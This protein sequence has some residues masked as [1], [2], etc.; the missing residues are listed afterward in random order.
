MLC[1][2]ANKIIDSASTL[3]GT[4]FNSTPRRRREDLLFLGAALNLVLGPA[5]TKTSASAWREKS[6]ATMET[7]KDLQ[8]E[9]AALGRV[10][11]RLAFTADGNMSKVLGGLLPKLLVR[12]DE[13]AVVLDTI[14]ALPKDDDMEMVDGEGKAA[15]VE[16]TLETHVR[17]QIVEHVEAMFGHALERIKLNRTIVSHTWIRGLWEACVTTERHPV[18]LEKVLTLLQHA[19]AIC[20]GESFVGPLIRLLDQLHTSLIESPSENPTTL[21]NWKCAGWMVLDEIAKAAHLPVILD[22]DRDGLALGDMS[23]SRAESAPAASSE[24]IEAARSHGSGIFHL[25]LDV[26]LLNPNTDR[27]G[28]LSHDGYSRLQH[29]RRP[30]EDA[31]NERHAGVEAVR[32][33]LNDTR[34]ARQLIRRAVARRRLPGSWSEAEMM[35]FRHIKLAC[36]RF[37]VWPPQEGLLTGDEAMVL[38]TLI[39]NENSLHS[40]VASEY[41][42]SLVGGRKLVR[43]GQR[44]VSPKPPKRQLPVVTCLLVL[45]VGGRRTSEVPNLP[46]DWKDGLLMSGKHA[47]KA[48]FER[49][50]LSTD[51]A[52]HVLRDLGN[53]VE[54]KGR[55]GSSILRFFTDLVQIISE[56]HIEQSHSNA[57]IRSVDA[58][59][60]ALSPGM[61]WATRVWYLLLR[62]QAESNISDKEWVSFLRRRCWLVAVGVLSKA[63]HGNIFRLNSFRRRQQRR[64][65]SRLIDQNR[66]KLG[67]RSPVLKDCIQT[68]QEAYEMVSQLICGNVRSPEG[69]V[70][71]G[72]LILLLKCL[73]ADSVCELIPVLRETACR[74]VQV[75]TIEVASS[76]F[77]PQESRRLISS[78][79]FPL[80]DAAT[81]VCDLGRE[82][83]LVFA[84]SVLVKLDPLPARHLCSFLSGDPVPTISRKAQDALV[85]PEFV[86]EGTWGKPVKFDFLDLK[87][88]TDFES[89]TNDVSSRA[90]LL[91]V[92][93]GI[94]TAAGHC[95]LQ[96]SGF[97]VAEAISAAQADAALIISE[98]GVTS[99]V[100]KGA[101]MDESSGFCMHKNPVNVMC[102]ICYEPATN[103]GVFA[104]PCDHFFCRYCWRDLIEASFSDGKPDLLS[105]TC[106]QQRCNESLVR[107][108]IET[109]ASDFLGKWDESTVESFV[110]RCAQYSFCPGPDCPIVV[111]LAADVAKNRTVSCTSCRTS[112]CFQCGR[113]PHRPVTCDVLQRYESIMQEVM[114]K[115]HEIENMMKEC[116]GCT[117]K[118]QKNGGCN[119]MTCTQC[120]HQFCWVCMSSNWADHNCNVFDDLEQDDGTRRARF[121]SQRVVAQQESEDFAQHSLQ[122]LDKL[123]DKMWRKFSF[124]DDEAFDSFESALEIL[125]AARSFLKNSYISAFGLNRD[126]VYREEF[127][128]HQA[129]VT[130][131]TERLSLLTA[132]LPDDFDTEEENQVRSRFQAIRLTSSAVSLYIQR[133]DAFMANFMS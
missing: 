61:R 123:T 109:L 119:H 78:L 28:G 131:L 111:R 13:S 84:S 77:S 76:N 25:F 114:D 70:D 99:R 101:P 120:G 55:A 104:L 85:S 51:T 130:S 56:M 62:Q 89:V 74:F 71:V 34:G 27:T 82:F 67:T 73:A 112:F 8:S 86:H 52:D 9:L 128:T 43:E 68:R 92:T 116:P 33:R 127:E 98:S 107:E 37:A 11:N 132:N 81:S 17:K 100:L 22:W 72:P 31:L 66:E 42:W 60:A 14:A 58:F 106:P 88:A 95:I 124:L 12:M 40:K 26:F 53:N 102:A 15:E 29:R 6:P 16:D 57:Q 46:T 54:L 64:T 38:C 80:I 121:F 39:S 30:Q 118:I 50:P 129:H 7:V 91:A 125:I 87:N 10:R 5:V 1:D 75:Y 41:I 3:E 103:D 49:T 90:A 83:A 69:G 32:A 96:K 105:L 65:D 94:P 21:E 44:F 59:S 18:T 133:I 45:C 47:K 97:S 122:K 117:I 2:T 20:T 36:I 63:E 19:H 4:T 115:K 113:N 126:D 93:M 48:S 35:Y 23:W 110:L 79:L 24:A 108:D